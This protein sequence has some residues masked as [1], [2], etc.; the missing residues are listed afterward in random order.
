MDRTA[1]AI[2]EILKT[3]HISPDERSSKHS[4][5]KQ[6]SEAQQEL[7]KPLLSSRYISALNSLSFDYTLPIFGSSM[8]TS[9][10][11]WLYK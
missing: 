10:Q 7:M 8:G 5:W 2:Q 3:Y 1:L 9:F 4:I 11:S 6:F